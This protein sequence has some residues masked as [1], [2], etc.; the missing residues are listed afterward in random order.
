MIVMPAI[1]LGTG[2]TAADRNGVWIFFQYIYFV[3]ML[4]YLGQFIYAMVK[5]L[6]SMVFRH[7]NHEMIRNAVIGVDIVFSLVSS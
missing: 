6:D 1:T 2:I 7:Q 5:M 3:S 4:I